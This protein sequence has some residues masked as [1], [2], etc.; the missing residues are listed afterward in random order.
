[1]R[2]DWIEREIRGDGKEEVKGNNHN[3]YRRDT[4]E[5]V[6][7]R[8]GKIQF[9]LSAKQRECIEILLITFMNG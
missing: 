9:L 4:E 6:I 1:M 5:E 7:A 3:H 8:N 2:I